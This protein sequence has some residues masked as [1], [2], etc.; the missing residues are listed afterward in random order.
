MVDGP[1]ASEGGRERID[2][3]HKIAVLERTC[4][5]QARTL[6]SK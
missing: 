5:M 4:Q 2:V 1:E 3:R 6:A